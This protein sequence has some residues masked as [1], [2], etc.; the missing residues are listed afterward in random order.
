MYNGFLGG[1]VRRYGWRKFQIT[2]WTFIAS[3]LLL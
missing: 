2:S 1:L 3:G